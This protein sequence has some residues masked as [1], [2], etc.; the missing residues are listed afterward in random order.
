MFY[1]LK[2]FNF[3]LYTFN[4]D[5]IFFVHLLIEHNKQKRVKKWWAELKIGKNIYFFFM[6]C[7]TCQHL[8]KPYAFLVNL[9]LFFPHF[10]IYLQ[11]L[12]KS[13]KTENSKKKRIIQSFLI[14]LLIVGFNS[15]QYLL[16]I[17]QHF[18]FS[19]HYPKHMINLILAWV[20]L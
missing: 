5:A 12:V 11:I 9:S 15:M 18:L 8:K 7:V 10:P 14:R 19:R 2:K 17:T 1:F 6:I 3:N 20:L 16:N 4:L 13:S